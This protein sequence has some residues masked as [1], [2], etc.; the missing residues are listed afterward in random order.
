MKLVNFFENSKLGS[1]FQEPSESGCLGKQIK[2]GKAKKKVSEDQSYDD[3]RVAKYLCYNDGK[4]FKGYG[5]Q[6]DYISKAEGMREEDPDKYQSILRQPSPPSDD[7]WASKLNNSVENDDIQIE[8]MDMPDLSDDMIGT[9]DSFYDEEERKEAFNDLQDAMDN[10]RHDW[11]KETVIDGVCPECSGSSCMDGDEE[12]GEDSCYGWGNFGC[13][14]GEMTQNDDGLPNWAEIIKH[15]KRKAEREKAKADYPG[16]DEVIDQIARAVKQLDDPRQMFQY[17]KADYP[18]MGTAQRSSLIAQGMKKAGL[19]SESITEGEERSIIADACVEKLVDEF[20][21]RENQF[22]NKDDLE[23]AIYQAL[24]DLDVEDCV[25]PE[26]EVGGQPI[27][28]FASGRVI[29]CCSSS[30][31]IYDVMANMDETQIGEGRIEDTFGTD[32]VDKHDKPK[33]K[34]KDNKEIDE[35]KRLSGIKNEGRPFKSLDLADI[36]KLP[37]GKEYVFN[38]QKGMF[39]GTDGTY[40][41][42]Q[43]EIDPNSRSHKEL[44]RLRK[45][46]ANRFK[47]VKEDAEGDASQ[48]AVSKM[49]AKA[50]GDENRWTEMSAAELYAELESTNTEMADMVKDVAKMIYGVQL[51]ESKRDTHRPEDIKEGEGD[52]YDKLMHLIHDEE[53]Y[54]KACGLSDKE[55]DRQLGEIARDFGLHMDDD[56]YAIINRHAKEQEEKNNVKEEI[57]LDEDQ[58]FHEEFGVLGFSIDE[59]D[60]FEAEYQGRKVKLNKPMR[61]DV[62]KFKVY[63][64]DPKTGNVK[65]VNFGHGGT[66]AKRK[67]MRI[68]KSNPKARKS[69][70]A[71]HNCD[72]PGPKTKARYWSCRK[73]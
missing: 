1:G 63:V 20:G 43:E 56:R 36:V 30:D 58:D 41:G 47:G 59:N 64:K 15:D 37:N 69:F 26:M 70:R 31:I 11:Q 60:M 25:D 24:E 40:P 9:P 23:Y 3:L 19:T 34:K 65:K 10:C 46:Q 49:I 27:G 35:L 45:N 67:T 48:V 16:D 2:K 53:A 38:P 17:M 44:L 13:D 66:S 14:G 22:Q 12:N 5:T 39:I 33:K 62:K 7:S 61:G 28:D 52:L 54:A 29:D 42:G 73:W 4:K 51:S 8:E 6:S 72:N 57:T 68:R 18:H 55:L 32:T 21:G 50:L 71:R